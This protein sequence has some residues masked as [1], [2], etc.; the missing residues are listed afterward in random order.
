MSEPEK[1]P[2]TENIKVKPDFEKKYRALCRDEEYYEE[3]MKYSLS[4]LRRSIRINTLKADIDSVKKSL[5][6][7]GWILKQIPWSKEG[8]WVTNETGRRD[9]GNTKE[10]ALG[11]I[12]VQEAVSMIP[13]VVLDPQPG[14]TVLDMCASP[15]SKT[16]QLAMYMK[17]EGILLANDYQG[18]R[19]RPLG[20]NMQ[21]I[22]AT[23][24]LITLMDGARYR[25]IE[26]DRILVDA[27]CSGSGT[28]RK[29]LKTLRMWSENSIKRIASQQKTL[30]S[31]AFTLLKPGGT[32]VYSTCSLEPE[33]NEAMVDFLLKKFPEA[34]CVP[35]E[36]DMK[37]GEPVMEWNG[38]KFDE[39]VKN[40]LRIWPQDNDTEGFFVAKLTKRK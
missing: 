39:R 19:V 35:F 20:L 18:M 17:N 12:Y 30:I 16:S 31:N 15:G 11:Y 8:F 3:F 21:R 10:H 32:M 36:M 25:D 28:I 38:E 23:N 9:I 24:V 40:T 4:F 27:P 33:E 2:G 7:K 29:S 1:I 5:K 14:E 37:W 26:F 13:P 34:D 6:E 22:G